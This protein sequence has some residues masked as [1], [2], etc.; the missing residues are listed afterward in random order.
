VAIGK[1][2]RGTGAVALPAPR[3]WWL[4]DT[5]LVSSSFFPQSI[6]LIRPKLAN[7]LHRDG[8]ISE[9]KYADA[10]FVRHPLCSSRET[11]PAPASTR[12][13]RPPRSNG[14]DDVQIRNSSHQRGQTRGTS[15]SSVVQGRS[16]SSAIGAGRLGWDQP[17]RLRKR[18]VHRAA[19][20]RQAAGSHDLQ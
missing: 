15:S 13:S 11:R 10:T 3:A 12:S 6:E 8:W 2:P 7:P 4:R 17:T 9:G 1:L 19:C 16:T 18:S 20:L 14:H 5:L